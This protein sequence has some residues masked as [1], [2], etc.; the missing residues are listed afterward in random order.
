MAASGTGDS[1]GAMQSPVTWALLGLIIARASYAYEL[2]HRFE[3]VYGNA[4]TISSPSHIYW[5][6]GKLREL[7]LIQE[8]AA[9]SDSPNARRRYEA[10]EAGRRE[11]AAWIADQVAQ[12]QRRQRVVVAQIS[13]LAGAPSDVRATLDAY[14]Q[15]C[16]VA[17]ANAAPPSNPVAGTAGLIDRLA[18]EQTRLAMD[19]RL[20]WIRHAR[21]QL[22]DFRTS[23][24]DV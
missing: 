13:A 7:G 23:H 19:A 16:L 15:A 14:E 11:H 3:H 8:I 12:E 5:G 22:R 18:A 9:G 24:T 17:L 1:R 2:A 4:L 21:A 10:T 20:S 6:L